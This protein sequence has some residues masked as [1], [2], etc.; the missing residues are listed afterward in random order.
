MTRTFRIVTHKNWLAEQFAPL[1][2]TQDFGFDI[3]PATARDTIWWAPGAWVASALKSGV[4]LPLMSCGP[5]WLD[6]LPMR[7]RG[8]YVF[9]G[10][11]EYLRQI[12][13]ED[14]DGGFDGKYFIK[15]P[16]AK[17]EHFSAR[18]HDYNRHWATT[19][20]QYH[21]PG[22]ALIQIQ[23]PVE[24]V[25]EARFW[26]VHGEVVAESLYRIDDKVWGE[27]GFGPVQPKFTGMPVMMDEMHRLAAA[28]AEEISAPPGYV[29]DVGITTDVDPFVVEANA[30]W[31]SGPYDGDPA[32]V[33]KAI[34]ASH[35]FDGRYPQWAWNPNPVLHKA[36]PLKVVAAS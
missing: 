8:R 2:A 26:I 32:G 21:L 14:P 5:Y 28:V 6:E 15:L 1:G 10:T 3:D 19:I 7:Y 16:E 34:E 30:A 17:L 9:T 33:F 20:D 35:D 12:W 4:R 29:L 23:E 18:I 27:E 25:I 36:G 31:S 11:V 24:F 13:D 22:D